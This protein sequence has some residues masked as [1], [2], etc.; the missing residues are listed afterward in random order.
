[1]SELDQSNIGS[2]TA[3][4]SALEAKKKERM[5]YVYSLEVE[6]TNVNSALNLY[7]KYLPDWMSFGCSKRINRIKRLYSSR[8]TATKEAENCD[9]EILRLTK[10]RVKYVKRVLVEENKSNRFL[11]EAQASIKDIEEIANS[12]KEIIESIPEWVGKMKAALFSDSKDLSFTASKMLEVEFSKTI[13]MIHGKTKLLTSLI[14]GHNDK[15]PDFKIKIDSLSI[16]FGEDCLDSMKTG[17]VMTPEELNGVDSFFKGIAT[18]YMDK[19]Y[20]NI[21]SMKYI[22][23]GDVCILVSKKMSELA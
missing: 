4:I 14:Y 1:M 12:Y 11:F 13:S 5:Q 8:D 15:Y 2:Y 18:N 23:E 16:Q 6:I 17:Y 3:Q 7:E 22:I 21:M 10:L 20:L 9:E 19:V